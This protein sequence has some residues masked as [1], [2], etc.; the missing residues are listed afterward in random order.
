MSALRQADRLQGRRV[1]LRRW[2]GICLRWLLRGWA[3]TALVPHPMRGYEAAQA[4]FAALDI[5]YRASSLALGALIGAGRVLVFR[6][7]M[8]PGVHRIDLRML[9]AL[10]GR[11]G[12]AQ[13]G[14][15]PVAAGIEHGLLVILDAP[16]ALVAGDDHLRGRIVGEVGGACDSFG[17]WRLTPPRGNP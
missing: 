16:A 14:Q 4:P 2:R 15:R 3:S 6:L 7:A 17:Q 5:Y 8:L 13:R 12:G 11:D 9:A 1:C 10:A